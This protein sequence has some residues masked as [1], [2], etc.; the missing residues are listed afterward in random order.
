MS[1]SFLIVDDEPLVRMDIAEIVREHGFDAVEAG[2]TAEALGILQQAG[3]AFFGLITDV[4]MPGTRSGMVLANHVRAV[5]PH[6]RIVVVSGGR[7]PFAGE[8]PDNTEF[9]SKPWRTEQIVT[10][11][12]P[13]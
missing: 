8:L 11:I 13:A 1:R 4:N 10:A 3:H 12:G 6:I 2:S 5:W 7:K 9:I